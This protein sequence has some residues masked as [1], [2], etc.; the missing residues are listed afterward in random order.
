LSPL[1]EGQEI[2]KVGSKEFYELLEANRGKV[3]LVDFWASSSIYCR[4]AVPF[5]NELYNHYK[6]Q[7]F[8]IISISV[9]LDVKDAL[10]FAKTYKVEYPVFVATS[11][12]LSE[13]RITY[14]PHYVLIDRKGEKR[15]EQVGLYEMV[16]V[17]F[18]SRI[19]KL[20]EET[21]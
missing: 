10:D 12:L 9:E 15:H 14:V 5:L 20:L 13:H 16:I 4:K 6:G 7:G 8:E 1:A 17:E 21:G 18:E 19:E 3:I 11:E 2:K